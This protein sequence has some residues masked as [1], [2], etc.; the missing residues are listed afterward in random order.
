MVYNEV[1]QWMGLSKE[2]KEEGFEEPARRI[3]ALVKELQL[4]KY[5]GALAQPKDTGQY[6]QKR[7]SPP[8]Y[9]F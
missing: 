2:L 4:E 5:K 1:A 6:E 3:L 8:D 7:S 9:D